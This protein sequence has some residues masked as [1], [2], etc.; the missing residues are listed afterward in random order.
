MLNIMEAPPP[1]ALSISFFAMNCPRIIKIAIG[2]IQESRKESRGDISC[3]ISL[4]NFA[5]DAYRRS[6]LPGSSISPV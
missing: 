5:P 1:P 6:V 2:R 3:T 4:E